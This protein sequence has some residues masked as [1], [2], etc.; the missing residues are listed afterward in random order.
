MGLGCRETRLVWFE[1]LLG[2][3]WGGGGFGAGKRGRVLMCCLLQLEIVSNAVQYVGP[4]QRGWDR[5]DTHT[6]IHIKSIPIKISSTL[7]C[8]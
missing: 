4:Y 6:S 1:F 8:S 5:F 3:C 2:G 7:L